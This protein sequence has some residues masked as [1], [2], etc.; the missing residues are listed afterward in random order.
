MDKD[1]IWSKT[2]SLL[3]EN[4]DESDPKTVFLNMIS[5][6]G[7]FGDQF[8]LLA[9][10]AAVEAWVKN[11]YL[12]EMKAAVLQVNGSPLNIGLGS[13]PSSQQ[14]QTQ[15]PQQASSN[16]SVPK[17]IPSNQMSDE[18]PEWLHYYTNPQAASEQII[19]SHR[20]EARTQSTSYEP[21]INKENEV[22][23]SKCTFETFVAGDTNK[24]AYSAALAV[25]EQPGVVNNPFFIYGNSGLGKT[26]LLVAI[27]NYIM[28]NSPYMKTRYV[29]ANQFLN[30]YVE[31]TQKNS[32]VDFNNKYQKMDI[33]LIDDIQYLE[34]REGTLNQLFNIFNDMTNNGKQIVLSADRPPKDIIMDARLTTRM[35]SGLLIDVKLPE[36]ETRLAILKKYLSRIGPQMNFSSDIP[37]EVLS[38][39]AQ[40]DVTNIREMEG[41]IRRLVTHMMVFDK[42]TISVEE[43]QEMLQDF[44]SSGKDKQVNISLIQSEVEKFFGISHE[45]MVSSKRSKS[46]AMPR[47]VAIY[48]SRVHTNESLQ[49]IGMQFGGRDHTTIMHSVQKIEGEQKEDRKLM[50]QLVSLERI[51]KERS[52]G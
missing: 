22:L 51:I 25:A 40:V 49:A 32:W 13:N 12:E 4:V 42:E 50:D 33:L 23:F 24:L 35:N 2:L 10:S 45:D 21:P 5:P 47:H 38:Y 30:D 17:T 8:V 14:A 19:E 6:V 36:Y 3:L 44:F 20:P 16:V 46:I 48:L 29:S 7:V 26:H 31:A 37:D 52:Q 43:A 28:Q 27:A 15:A 18:E 11:N 39:I 34:G 41:S 1:E 9:E